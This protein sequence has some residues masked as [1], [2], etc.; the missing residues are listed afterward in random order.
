MTKY[1]FWE[2][3]KADNEEAAAEKQNEKRIAEGEKGLSIWAGCP[4][5]WYD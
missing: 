2:D 1:E 4:G 5:N 3:E